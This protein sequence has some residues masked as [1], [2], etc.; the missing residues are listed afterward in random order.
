[1][2]NMANISPYGLMLGLLGLLGIALG[3]AARKEIGID[4]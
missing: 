1:M 3:K 4:V 2:A